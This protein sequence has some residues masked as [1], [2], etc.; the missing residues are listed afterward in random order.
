MQLRSQNKV[1]NLR[2]GGWAIAQLVG[3]RVGA[4][5][6]TKIRE[7]RENIE[8]SPVTLTYLRKYFLVQTVHMLGV[9]EIAQ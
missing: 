9:R 3:G 4:P 5:K 1:S 7:M 6:Q 8:M 2:D